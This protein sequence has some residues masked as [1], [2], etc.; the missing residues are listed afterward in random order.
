MKRKITR[1]AFAGNGGDF[2][3]RA[4]PARASSANKPCSAKAPKPAED[5]RNISRREERPGF[6]ILAEKTHHTKC[7][8]LLKGE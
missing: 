8:G 6:T 1:L 5:V 4:E 2:G 7:T 3:A